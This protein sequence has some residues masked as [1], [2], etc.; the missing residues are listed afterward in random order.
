MLEAGMTGRSALRAYSSRPDGSS[1]TRAATVARSKGR[2]ASSCCW[3]GVGRVSGGVEAMTETL[4]DS[5]G[6]VAGCVVSTGS[7]IALVD[8]FVVS[9]VVVSGD[10]FR[11]PQ[12]IVT[13]R[14]RDVIRGKVEVGR[15][16]DG[17]GIGKT[18]RRLAGLCGGR[19]CGY[20]GA[21]VSRARVAPGKV[22][23]LS[24]WTEVLMKRIGTFGV[25]VMLSAFLALG[26]AAQQPTREVTL[27][28]GDPAPPLYIESWVKGEPVKELEKGKVY[29]ME[30]W[31]TWCGPCIA[32]FPHVTELQKKYA[33]KGVTVIGVD[34]WESERSTVPEFVKKQGDKMGYTVAMEQID[35]GADRNDGKMS[36]TWMFA[37]GRNGIPCSF[38]I[39]REGKIAWIGHP[40]T[41]DRPLEQ[42]VAGTFD[43]KANAEL[44]A[45]QAAKQQELSAAM[46]ARDWD[47]AVGLIDGMIAEEPSSAGVYNVY[48]LQVLAQKGDTATVNALAKELA[49][50]GKRDQQ[51][52]VVR[53]MS[54]APNAKQLDTELMLS[55]AK[56]LAD[57]AEPADWQSGMW[58]ARVYAVREEFDKAA[59]VQR[60]VVQ[61][62]DPRV[63]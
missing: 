53:I 30:F 9:S 39:D 42:V 18:D 23:Y 14:R 34:I 59:E 16:M 37:A 32:A 45:K 2:A 46:R 20:G 21:V 40:M 28:V 43:A 54:G 27:K 6:R 62:A 49:A 57:K 11:Q 44:E 52:A 1:I 19:H 5:V 15:A 60:E 47:K 8:N 31:A 4:A 7:T 17:D 36:K 48:K 24:Y 58:L 50:S 38:I 33:D 35:A 29:V 10:L 41:M 22:A 25:A 13:H 63:K 51:A 61:K 26:A 56:D 55:V 3:S 12:G